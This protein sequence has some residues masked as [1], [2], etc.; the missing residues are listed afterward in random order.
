M[1]L[2]GFGESLSGVQGC[3]GVTAVHF[4]SRFECQVLAIVAAWP[5]SIAHAMAC[6]LS[7]A[8]VSNSPSCQQTIARYIVALAD[9]IGAEAK[10]G[11]TIAARVI[12]PQHFLEMSSR[13]HEMA[14]AK[15]RQTQVTK[16]GRRFR[17][18]CGLHC[19]AKES[20]SSLRAPSQFGA[21]ETVD[22]LP[23]EA[24]V[25][26]VRVVGASAEFVHAGKGSLRFLSSEP[27]R[28]C[29]RQAVGGLKFEP[30]L[31]C[32]SSVLSLRR[33]RPAWLEAP[34]PPRFAGNSGAGAKPS[35]AGVSTA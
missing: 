23:V 19:F 1:S 18:A 6:S 15:A 21:Q 2:A 28:P 7:L 14:L 29:H 31:A 22:P 27:S 11:V 34:A 16:R 24:S 5:V 10:F 9:S 20:L 30:P 25:S 32:R 8:P 17:H 3:F 33:C 12:Y 35:S 4:K 26:L 13:L